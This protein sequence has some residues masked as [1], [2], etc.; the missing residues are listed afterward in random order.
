MKCYQFERLIDYAEG[1]L[2]TNAAEAARSH[3]A[4]GCGRCAADIDWY[5]RVKSIAAR[6]ESVA[7][8]AW[9][10]NGAI[11]AFGVQRDRAGLKDRVG[12]LIGS[13]V[14]DSFGK[15]ALAGV[16]SAQT[17]A[18][19]LL[20]RA[21]P[22]SIDVKV[23]SLDHG[24]AELTGQILREGE[25]K[26][27]SVAGLPL[28]LLRDGKKVLTTA[29]NDRGEFSIAELDGGDYEL[30]IDMMESSITIAGLPVS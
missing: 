29:T 20:Y 8:P 7:P 13:L 15:T 18:R 22:Y 4:S 16:R 11:K 27:E 26:F 9:V 6:D 24:R 2:A 23:G 25:M 1:M 14:F 21:A 12:K 3:L 5:T 28:L 30:R 17:E 10:F 19:Q